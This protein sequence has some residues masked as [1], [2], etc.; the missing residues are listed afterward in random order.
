MKTAITFSPSHEVHTQ[1]GH[2]ERPERLQAIQT[3]LNQ[4]GILESLMQVKSHLATKEDVL[5]VHPESYYDSLVAAS[6]AGTVW[7]DSDTYSTPGS[8]GVALEAL[9]GLLQVTEA[10]VKEKASNGFAIVRPPGHHARPAEAMG[11][12]LLA[13]ISIAARWIQKNTNLRRILIVDFDVHHGNGT[14]EIFYEDP[15]VLYISTHQSPLYPGTGALL[16]TGAKEGNRSTINIPLPAKTGDDTLLYVFKEILKPRVAQF[17]PE[18]ILVSAGYDAHWL[19]PIGG[20]NITVSG[21]ASVLKEILDWATTYASERL[22]AL[23]EGGYH[24]EALAHSVLTTLRLMN[25][26][27][28]TASDPFGPNPAQGSIH[29]QLKNYLVEIASI[30]AL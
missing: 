7:L 2:V 22:V 10:V 24:A 15:D 28:A 18:F 6:E 1:P 14:Q 26:R 20:M 19:D 13:N 3:L 8:L 29:D 9:G 17:N 4:D 30:H 27:Q 25:S 5:L 16:E 23:L 21:F 12:C 11:F